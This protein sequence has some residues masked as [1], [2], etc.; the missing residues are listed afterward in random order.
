MKEKGEREGGKRQREGEKSKKD[1]GGWYGSTRVKEA[2]VL[3]AY[4]G[5]YPRPRHR[6]SYHI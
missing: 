4:R 3:T 2:G 1:R 6:P 5:R